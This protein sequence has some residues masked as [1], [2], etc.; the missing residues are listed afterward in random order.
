[1]TRAAGLGRK[2]DEALVEGHHLVVAAAL[3]GELEDA[4]AF[5]AHGADQMLHLGEGRHA[6]RDRP[7]VGGEVAPGCE[8]SRS[9]ARPARTASRTCASMVFRSSSAGLFLEGA[10]THDIGA[11]RRMADIAR[12]V[13]ALGRG[14]HGGHEL[15]EGL[16]TPVDAGQHGVAVDILRALQVAEHEV[17][18]GLAAGSEREAA[19]AHHRRGDAVI[20][21]AGAE[22]V[23]EQLRV[24]VG[25]AVHEAGRHHMCPRHRRPRPPGRRCARCARSAHP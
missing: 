1:M 10:L 3:H 8:R 2:V 17:G 4:G 20:A 23:P 6:A 13:D 16:P 15:G 14:I 12:I 25:V 5:I 24:H 22:L 21:G 19:I 11:Q 18:F 9:R 7:V